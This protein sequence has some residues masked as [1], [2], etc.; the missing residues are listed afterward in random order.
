M[1]P[2]TGGV[3]LRSAGPAENL[4]HIKNADVD[5]R[6]LLRVVNLRPCVDEKGGLNCPTSCWQVGHHRHILYRRHQHIPALKTY[7]IPASTNCTI[8]KF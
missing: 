1:P 8:E 6:A 3:K 7:S 2:L 4:Q 5:E